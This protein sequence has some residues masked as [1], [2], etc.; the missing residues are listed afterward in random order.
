MLETLKQDY[1]TTARSKGLEERIVINKHAKR[2]AL[3]P[4]TTISG[5]IIYGLLLGVFVT[6][7]VFNY[8]GLGRWG[9]EATLRFDV[10]AV[11]GIVLFSTTLIV[12]VNLVVDILYTFID[13]RVRYD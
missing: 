7:T 12:V 13:P 6:E 10:P 11:I 3:L 5:F 1:I 2:N 9:I 8:N 4:V